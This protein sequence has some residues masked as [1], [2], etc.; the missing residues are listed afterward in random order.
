MKAKKGNKR[1]PQ[2]KMKEQMGDT[3]PHVKK[4]N[5]KAKYKHKSHWLQQEDDY[6]LPKYQEEEEE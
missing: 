4:R 1:G 6:E 3:I 2:T 5:V